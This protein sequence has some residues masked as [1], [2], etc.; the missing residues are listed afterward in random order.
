MARKEVTFQTVNGVVIPKFSGGRA[1]RVHKD[2]KKY[3][4]RDRRQN[5]KWR[6]FS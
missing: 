3:T 5:K 1:T 4:R 2:N 6:D